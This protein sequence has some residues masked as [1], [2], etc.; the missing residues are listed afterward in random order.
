MDPSDEQNVTLKKSKNTPS[1]TNRA[2]VGLFINKGKY[3][4]MS[5]KT[6]GSDRGTTGALSTKRTFWFYTNKGFAITAGLS[7]LSVLGNGIDPLLEQATSAT[8]GEADALAIFTQP[9]W[10]RMRSYTWWRDVQLIHVP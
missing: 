10:G 2:L 7:S 8:P 6:P 4:L 3:S 1:L 5:G 9:K